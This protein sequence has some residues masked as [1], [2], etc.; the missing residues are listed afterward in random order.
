MKARCLFLLAFLVFAGAVRAATIEQL[1]ADPQLWPTEVTV[2]AATGTW[3]TCTT[4]DPCFPSTVA[5]I[6]AFPGARPVTRPDDETVASDGDPLDQKIV[7]P[8]SGCPETLRGVATSCTE[9]PTTMLGDAGETSTTATGSGAIVTTAVPVAPSLVAVI[10][11]APVETPVTRPLA[12][13]V[14]TCVL[15]DENETDCP[16]ST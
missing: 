8:A 3:R 6:T 7:R 1:A 15:F 5:T 12:E 16:I 11:A 4:A 10:V 14:A 13:T 2:T 9:L